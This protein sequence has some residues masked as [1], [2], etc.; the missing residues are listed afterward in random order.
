MIPEHGP[1]DTDSYGERN[2]YWILKTGLPDDYT[3]IHSLPWLC[4]AVKKLDAKAK[5]T[6]EIDFLIIHPENGVLALE[7]KSGVYR[8]EN[9]VFVHVRNHFTIDPV[10]QTRKNVHGLSSWLGGTPS[11]FLKIGYGFIFPDSDFRAVPTSPGMYD[12][13]ANPPQPLYIDYLGMPNVTQHVIQLMKYWKGALSNSNLGTA[14]V[15]ELIKFL[16]PTIN[17]QPQ[18]NSRVLFD[19]KVWLQLTNE[20]SLVVHSVVKNKTSLI[21]GWPGTGKTLIAIEAA[22]KLAVEGN[23]VLIISFNIKLLDHIRNQLT[24][25][26]SCTALTWHALCRQAAKNLDRPTD[27]EDWYKTS[28]VEDLRD[29]INQNLL[30]DYDALIVDESQALTASWCDTLATWFHLKTKAFFCDETQVFTFERESVSL[31]ELTKILGVDPFPLTI[32]LRMP[33]AVTEILSEVVPPKLQHYSPRTLEYDTAVEIITLSPCEDLVSIRNTLIESGINSDDIVILTG[34]IIGRLYHKFLTTGKIDNETIA[35]F[36]GLEAPIIIIIGAEQ[37]STSELFSAYSRATT[38]CI[39]IYNAHNRFWKGSQGFQSRLQKNPESAAILKKE[40]VAL[41][42]R[43]LVES[44][45]GTDSLNLKSLDIK[46]GSSW[47][48]WL[49]ENESHESYLMLWLEHLC[50][51]LAHPIF[52]WHKGTLTKFYQAKPYKLDEQESFSCYPMVL[53]HCNICDRLTPHTDNSV[54]ECML[55]AS[56]DSRKPSPNPAVI[57]EINLF[58]AVITSQLPKDRT[59]ELQPTLPICIA[60]AAAL[61]RA[62]RRK[63][64]TNV[65]Q[66]PLPSGRS[67]YLAAFAFTQSRIATHPSNTAMFVNALADEI[68]GRFKS[69]EIITPIEWRKVF[70]NAFATFYQ[71]GYLIKAGKGVYRP[72][73]DN[74][75]PVPKRPIYAVSDDEEEIQS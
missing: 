32:I 7:V 46:W 53:E 57:A 58:D 73:E 27:K 18:W 13:T 52:Y 34:S 51:K 50:Q 2:L 8:V 49:I 23:R 56:G 21:T 26:S 1:H 66:V 11:L 36:R 31:M 37:L 41:R 17:G 40:Q 12:T 9:S 48:A 71:K 4:A 39:A 16:T 43:S 15:A 67:L 59:L 62:Q 38:K 19:N 33:K 6:G 30:E 5:P 35:K 61:L 75:A 45:T 55:C 54:N 72:V 63:L 22:R 42:I 68:Y 14:K 10:S 3:V 29:A 64:R 44:S 20:Q 74:F 69:L 25:Y 70:S 60:A 24:D 65:L 28:C 47:R